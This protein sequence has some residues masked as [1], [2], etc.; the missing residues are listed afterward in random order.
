MQESLSHEPCQLVNN[1]IGILTSWYVGNIARIALS[2]WAA[3][4]DHL[5]FY[6]KS[7]GRR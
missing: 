1:T 4:I 5:H 6:A 7:K 3:A 2:Q